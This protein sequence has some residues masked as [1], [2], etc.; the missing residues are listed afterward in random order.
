MQISDLTIKPTTKWAW[1]KYRL[2]WLRDQ[3]VSTKLSKKINELLDD[4]NTTVYVDNYVIFL[5]DLSLW[6]ANFPFAYG[7]FWDRES[8][9]VLIPSLME[10]A[11]DTPDWIQAKTRFDQ[12]QTYHN[13]YGKKCPDAA[14]IWRLRQVELAARELLN[15]TKA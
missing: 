11:P 13:Q 1:F 12:L 4:P 8:N 7:R 6:V 9:Y 3:P 15:S 5:G 2:D 10:L 14:T